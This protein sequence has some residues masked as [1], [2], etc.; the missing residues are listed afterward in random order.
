MITNYSITKCPYCTRKN[1]LTRV[2]TTKDYKDAY[3][4]SNGGCDEVVLTNGLI[5]ILDFRQT[6]LPGK[7]KAIRHPQRRNKYN[8]TPGIWYDRDLKKIPIEPLTF[9]PE[10]MKEIVA[11]YTTEI[12]EN[13]HVEYES[14]GLVVKD[15]QKN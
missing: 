3:I 8:K 15:E 10:D 7:H 6:P 13:E 11:N 9:N 5:K 12:A 14:S 4:C 1:D 2:R